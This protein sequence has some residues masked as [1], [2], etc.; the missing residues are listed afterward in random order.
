ME[1]RTY[2][3]LPDYLQWQA[4]KQLKTIR[5]IQNRRWYVSLNTKE[6][7]T[8]DGITVTTWT[9]NRETKH[10]LF[11]ANKEVCEDFRAMIN[12]C[13]NNEAEVIYSSSIDH[14]TM[15]NRE[16]KWIIEDGIEYI[17]RK[18]MK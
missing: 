7:G 10:T 12:F 5:E 11:S 16:Y 18:E 9:G 13:I 3:D 17:A 14:W 8:Y 6:D 4:G 1:K 2:I 15:D